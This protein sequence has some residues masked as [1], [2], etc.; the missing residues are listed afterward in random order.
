[1]RISKKQKDAFN[2]RL[3]KRFNEL[4]KRIADIE[5]QVQCQQIKEFIPEDSDGIRGSHESISTH[6]PIANHE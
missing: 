2:K 4:E 6:L 3:N 5:V 1:M